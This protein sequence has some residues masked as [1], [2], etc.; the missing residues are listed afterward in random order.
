MSDV[1]IQMEVCS[2]PAHIRF[3]GN[4]S[5]VQTVLEHLRGTEELAISFAKPFHAEN[6]ASLA[7]RSHDIG[8]FS[9]EFRTHILHPE[10]NMRVDHSTAG[11]Q[12]ICGNLPAAFAVA[13]HHGGLPDGGN[14]RTATG[15]DS[16]LAGR[17]KR[18]G[19]PDCSVWKQ[20]LTLPTGGAPDFCKA[21]DRLV[22]QFYTRMLYSCLVDADFLDTERF[23]NPQIDR[24]TEWDLRELD[25]RL[26]AYTD[27]F[28]PPQGALNEMRC[29]VLD[30]CRKAG[31]GAKGLYSLTVPTG[32]GKTLASLTFA[33]RH[34]VQHRMDRVIYVIPYTSIIDQTAETFRKVLGETCVLEHH[35]GVLFDDTEAD[36]KLAL[37]SENW[38][39]PVVVTTA[40]QFFESLYANRSSKCRKLHNLANSVIVFDEAQMLPL[41]YLKPCVFGIA[42]LIRHYEASALLCT[43]TQPALEDFFLDYGLQTTEICQDREH[44]FSAFR[45]TTVEQIGAVSIEE[46]GAQLQKKSQVLCVVNLRKTAADLAQLL[47]EEGRFCL[48]TLLCPADRKRLLNEIRQRLKDGLPCRVISTSLIEAGVDVDFPSAYRE[49]A[50]LDSILQTAGR[51]NREGKRAAEDSVVTVFSLPKSAPRMIRQ[52]IEATNRIIKKHSDLN[53]PEAI[54]AYFQFLRSLKGSEELDRQHVLEA[55]VRGINGCSFP[56]AQVADRFRLID[57]PTRT[58]YI[59]NDESEEL[60]AQLRGRQFSRNLFRRLGQYGV[61]VYPHHFQVLQDAGAISL[62]PSGDGILEDHTLYDPAFGLQPNAEPDIDRYIL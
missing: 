10:R 33:L 3:D 21:S 48:T 51:C 55:F 24:G 11:A 23:M 9:V 13:G 15:D 45:R 42:E 60:I 62:L 17:L 43:A 26:N 59:L 49:L 40:V 25:T 53:Q 61:N 30:A 36:Q 27:C 4:R 14:M 39:M 6:D 44:M 1:M 54:A 32:G 38:D 18:K 5:V 31:K 2:F 37:A 7:A 29:R 35:S 20:L 46:L 41:P 34:A 56:F 12:A 16:T 19:L 57:S 58:V 22:W 50:G 28:Y 8:K 52:N 47:P